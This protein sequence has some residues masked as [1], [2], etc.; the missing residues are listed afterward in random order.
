MANSQPTKEISKT[1]YT[2]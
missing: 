2:S 1:Y